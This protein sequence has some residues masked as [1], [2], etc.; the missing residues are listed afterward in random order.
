MVRQ[1]TDPTSPFYAV[2]EYPNDL[3]E[4]SPCPTSCSGTGPPLAAPPSS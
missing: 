4:G 1:S 3:T 2:L